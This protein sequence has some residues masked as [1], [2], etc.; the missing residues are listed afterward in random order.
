MRKELGS[1]HKLI[2]DD[3]KAA[4]RSRSEMSRL[5]PEVLQYRVEGALTV[6]HE[7]RNI[8][9]LLLFGIAAI[10]AGFLLGPLVA[11]VGV[12]GAQTGGTF[13][14]FG[15][16][17]WFV[18]SPC[19]PYALLGCALGVV[20][21]L[22]SKKEVVR[23]ITTAAFLCPIVF[24]AHLCLIYL[25]L[26]DSE[27]SI[28]LGGRTPNRCGFCLPRGWSI[29]HV[30]ERGENR[31]QYRQEVNRRFETLLVAASGRGDLDEVKD[32]LEF[33]KT[34]I[35][36][37]ENGYTPLMMASKNG[38]ADVVQVLLEKGANINL[39]WAGRTA[40]QTALDM[41]KKAGHVTVETL[42]SKAAANRS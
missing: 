8:S 42:L 13:T 5:G 22:T 33:R 27:V 30:N 40:G 12:Y 26:R 35:N 2:Q 41:A 4:A 9:K 29:L 24:A 14:G 32:L 11:V 18:L 25:L 7:S 37:C 3:N 39:K 6:E 17:A 21:R 15:G 38:H 1:G 36:S 16:L 34:P 23:L 20:A 10:A 31:S 19:T 28:R